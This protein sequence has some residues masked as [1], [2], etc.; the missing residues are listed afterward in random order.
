MDRDRHPF[1]FNVLD[2]P[3]VRH[4]VLYIPVEKVLKENA[5]G[6]YCTF[7]RRA[8]SLLKTLSTCSYS[9]SALYL[10]HNVVEVFSQFVVGVLLYTYFFN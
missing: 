2:A 9:R 10:A 1:L 3:P 6:K 7:H 4:P 5:S 8:T